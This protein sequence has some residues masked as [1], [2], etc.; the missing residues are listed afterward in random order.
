MGNSPVSVA[1]TLSGEGSIGTSGSLTF[2]NGSFLRVNSGTV[3]AL[4]VG[5]GSTGNLT[6]NATTKYA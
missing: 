5:S 1:G 6:L 4:T 2:N 3:G